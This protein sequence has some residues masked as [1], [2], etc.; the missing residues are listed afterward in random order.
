MVIVVVFFALYSSSGTDFDSAIGNTLLKFADTGIT[1]NTSK[2]ISGSLKTT[3]M[4]AIGALVSM[5]FFEIYNIF[6]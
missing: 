3:G 5:V 6:K 2:I 1:E 4:L